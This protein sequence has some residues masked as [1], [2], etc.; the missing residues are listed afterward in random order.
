MNTINRIFNRR[1]L[2]DLILGILVLGSLWGLSEIALGGVLKAAGFPY[3]SGL[4]TGI[5]M[6]VMGMALAVSRKPLIPI[7]VGAVA[8]LVGLL[9][10]PVLHVSPM[11]RANSSLAVVLESGSLTLAA[12]LIASRTG[13]SVYGRMATGGSAALLASVAFY[14]AGTHFAPCAYLLSFS[15]GSFVVKEGLVWAAFSTILLPVGYSAG[16]RLAGNQLTVVRQRSALYSGSGLV[17]AVCWG[18]S[19]LALALGL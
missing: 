8:V 13:K 2:I 6:A 7:G 9:V 3:R 1:G 14:F 11:C 15:A 12:S 19:A 17:V 16:E 18:I 4:L 5:G 10:V